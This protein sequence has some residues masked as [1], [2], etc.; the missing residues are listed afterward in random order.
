VEA[1]EALDAARPPRDASAMT[2]LGRPWRAWLAVYGA[3]VVVSIALLLVWEAAV[4]VLRLPRV[5]LPA[6][7]GVL[8]QLVDNPGWLLNHAS[9]TLFETLLG[10]GLGLLIGVPLAV[11]IVYSRFLES[12][13]YT[14]LAVTNSIPKIAIAPLF[15]I[16]LGTG[17]APKVAVAFM[18][19]LFPIV[20]DTVV[21]LRSVPPEMLDLARSMGGSHRKVFWKIRLPSALPNIFAGTKVA[22]SLAIVGA[23]VGEFVGADRGLGYVIMTSQG[24]FNT[25]RMF[26]AMTVLALIGIV[27]FYSV[28]YMER[29]TLPWHV[30]RRN[31][32][33]RHTP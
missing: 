33:P 1:V 6:P 31:D 20:I 12:T 10:F 3:P 7:S 9:H 13:F 5:I 22:I 14:L 26:A 2:P 8:G 15:I 18:I 23:V 24:Q 4:M 19:A 27:L 17:L 11:A 16:W 32:A 28:D 29:R 21:G 25:P 30:S